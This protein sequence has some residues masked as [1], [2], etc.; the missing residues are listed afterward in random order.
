MSTLLLIRGA[1]GS[2]KSTLGV[3]LAQMMYAE[4]FEADHF[5]ETG[6]GE[7]NFDPTQLGKAHVWCQTHT[8][9]ALLRG[10][11]VVVSNT[12]TTKDEVRVYEN[13]AKK[14]N[15]QFFSVIKENR[16][17]GENIHGVPPMKVWTQKERIKKSM[18]L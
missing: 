12:A 13:I 18:I 3:W 9:L 2:G 7:Y 17:G 5:F 10:D 14:C 11:D 8:E 15:A 1:S 6:P 16:H 4:H